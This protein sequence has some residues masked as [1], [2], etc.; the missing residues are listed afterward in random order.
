MAPSLRMYNSGAYGSEAA[1]ASR[2]LILI[3]LFLIETAVV[4]CRKK[5]GRRVWNLG[6]QVMPLRPEPSDIPRAPFLVYQLTVAVGLEPRDPKPR[7]S[8]F[9]RAA[10]ECSDC[11]RQREALAGEGAFG[12]ARAGPAVG[13]LVALGSEAANPVAEEFAALIN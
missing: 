11:N 4:S 6:R 3:R 9:C 1:S 12:A 5:K 10:A 7:R 8:S 13:A 2:P